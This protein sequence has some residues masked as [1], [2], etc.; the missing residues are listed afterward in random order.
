MEL[1]NYENNINQNIDQNINTYIINE[2]IE[3]DNSIESNKNEEI[4]IENEIAE[5]TEKDFKLKIYYE[6]LFPQYSRLDMDFNKLKI[7]EESIHYISIPK[8]TE[9]ITK[10]ITTHGKHYNLQKY[11]INI[12]DCT[13]GCGG[14][15]I[16]FARHFNFINSIELDPIRFS[17]LNNNISVYNFNNV[18]CYCD[19]FLNI[20]SK[21]SNHNVIYM[22]PPWGGP[23]YKL[24]NN[25]RF[26]ID[27]IPLE[28][29]CLDIFDN[30]KM[31]KTPKFMGIK[32]PKNYD[33][34]HFYTKITSNNNLKI[35]LYDLK[36]MY[37]LIIET[38]N[39]N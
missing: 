13:A 36:K 23:N 9:K 33:I 25:L 28:N 35:F 16:A 26:E 5:F 39:K 30:D 11:D 32:L 4:E 37:I 14:D 22:D 1:I 31:V 34:K 7:D 29:I 20:I 17:N 6:K 12:T 24:F 8:F 18:N 10:I 27:N 19:S 2:N 21:L 15:T 3:T 38:I